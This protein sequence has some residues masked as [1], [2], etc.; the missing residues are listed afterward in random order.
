MTEGETWFAQSL[1]PF[2][3]LFFLAT[4]CIF[5]TLKGC[6]GKVVQ[7]ALGKALG[8]EFHPW[9][10]EEITQYFTSLTLITSSILK[11]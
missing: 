11:S 7:T 4:S 6:G 2:G 9:R 10:S 1:L 8:I 5:M 3:L